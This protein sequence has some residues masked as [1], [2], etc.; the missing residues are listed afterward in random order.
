MVQIENEEIF[1]KVIADSLIRI[2]GNSN[3]PTWEKTRCIN[4]IA[5]AAARIK[6]DGCF[7]DWDSNQDRLLIWSQGSNELYEVNSSGTCQCK[8]FQGG[9]ICWH[10]AAKRLVELYNAAMLEKWCMD[11]RFR[12]A[13]RAADAAL[14]T[15]SVGELVRFDEVQIIE[16]Q[17]A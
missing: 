9:H 15:A 5:K 7:M 16:A 4:A 8:A 2:D 1:G 11:S 6:D 13:M 14:A 17:A 12:E 10:R 3:L